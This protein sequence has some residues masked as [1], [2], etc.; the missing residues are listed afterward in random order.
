MKSKPRSSPKFLFPFPLNLQLE[1]VRIQLLEE[2]EDLV[3]VGRVRRAA[4]EL[5]A[6]HLKDVSESVGVIDV[7]VGDPFRPAREER[8]QVAAILALEVARGENPSG[9]WCS[10]PFT[11]LNIPACAAF[12]TSSRSA[13]SYRKAIAPQVTHSWM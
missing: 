13:G 3:D 10:D 12:F 4:G 1:S 6:Q 5:V 7:D 8:L 11:S 9:G 2:H